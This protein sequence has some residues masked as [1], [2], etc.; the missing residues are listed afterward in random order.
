LDQ[1]RPLGL[2]CGCI[3]EATLRSAEKL[4]RAPTSKAH[5]PRPFS[6][7]VGPA[8]QECGLLR[9]RVVAVCGGMRRSTVVCEA[10]QVLTSCV[11][12]VCSSLRS[13]F[14]AAPNCSRNHRAVL[15]NSST[16]SHRLAHQPFC[17]SCR[18]SPD[19]PRTRRSDNNRL[20]CA[21]HADFA[22]PS[23]RPL[24][25][26]WSLAGYR[27]PLHVGSTPRLNFLLLHTRIAIPQVGREHT[28]LDSRSSP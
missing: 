22:R 13:F 24:P 16:P 23:I 19:S 4:P 12:H 18:Q 26:T 2:L 5:L 28:G 1:R 3:W 14:F 17:F 15:S 9:V 10:E 8:V 11:F 6:R 21:Y 20:V 7:A 27:R 25:I